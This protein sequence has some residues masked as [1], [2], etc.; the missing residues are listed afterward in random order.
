MRK[1]FTVKLFG[2]GRGE[3]AGMNLPFDPKKIWGRSRVPVAGTI[4]GF[5]FRSTVAPMG[6]KYF[7][8]VNRQMREGANVGVG[9]T[10]RVVLE[11]DTAPREV[12]VPPDLKKVLACTQAA[13]AAWDRSSYTHRKEFAK[14]INE[15]KKPETRERRLEKTIQ[16]LAAGEHL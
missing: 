2:A 13:K 11:P 5:K 15:A 10:V 9:D 14:W 16:M 8:C 6:R 12:E 1:E 4:N 7:I 3:V